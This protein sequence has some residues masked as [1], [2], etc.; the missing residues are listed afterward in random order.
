[1]KSYSPII[2]NWKHNVC[3]LSDLEDN[4]FKTRTEFLYQQCVLMS[5]EEVNIQMSVFEEKI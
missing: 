5:I 2:I 1:M 3:S 4:K